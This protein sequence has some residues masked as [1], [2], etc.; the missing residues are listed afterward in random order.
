VRSPGGDLVVTPGTLADADWSATRPE[1]FVPDEDGALGP[2]PA[3][4]GAS[5]WFTS[6][7]TEDG[8]HVLVELL[9]GGGENIRLEAA[10]SGI[11]GDLHPDG[12]TL[13]HIRPDPSVS[14]GPAVLTLDPGG[15]TP[16]RTLL[17]SPTPILLARWSPGGE[18]LLAV[19]RGVPD[20]LLVLTGDGARLGGVAWPTLWS[21]C[22]TSSRRI[23]FVGE[24]DGTPR[25]MLWELDGG[26][27]E[28]LRNTG[29]LAAPH[30]ACSPDGTAVAV[31]TMQDGLPGLE[32]VPLD[33]NPSR[34]PSVALGDIPAS[35]MW[36]P[37]GARPL[38]TG[39]TV[40]AVPGP[41]RWGEQYALQANVTWSDGVPRETPVD[42][43]ATDPDIVSVEP[44]G[45]ITTNRP[46]SARIVARAGGWRS[47]TL[48][49]EVEPRQVTEGVVIRES[50]EALDS[51]RWQSLGESA[52][53]VVEMGGGPA[54]EFVGDGDRQDGLILGSP[55]SLPRGGTVELEFLT[56]FTR[57][58]GQHIRLVLGTAEPR[59]EGD[60]SRWSGWQWDRQLV[61]TYP[62]AGPG[63][64]FNPQRISIE[65]TGWGYLDV[66]EEVQEGEWTHLAVQVRADGEVS[67]YMNHRY[68]GTAPGRLPVVPGEE[69]RVALLGSAVDT[70]LFVRNLV[71][72]GEPR[73]HAPRLIDQPPGVRAMA[74]SPRITRPG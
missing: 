46:G 15:E 18:Q 34:L 64:R 71:V 72:W 4:G 48:L 65:G 68:L 32:V 20:S 69:W 22:W 27:V 66:P 33:G 7:R 74:P 67:F 6:R 59:P 2:F 55:I 31:L 43:Q 13:L 10:G 45:V 8:A 42:W 56:E 41:L 16:A 3:P 14:G 37:S 60:P 26:A 19:T 29:P 49:V 11:L 1:G 44:D 21:A 51:T 39:V 58:D 12:R 23:A 52:P 63:G 53:R 40:E 62:E 17:R 61:V 5:R 36:V 24:Q 47:D 25:V 28:P 57:T 54:L 9:P 50:F 70:R 73:Y 30:L 38:I 35:L